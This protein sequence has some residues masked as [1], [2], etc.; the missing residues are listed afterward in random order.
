MKKVVKQARESD[1]RVCG[2]EQARQWDTASVCV[3]RVEG[4][5]SDQGQSRGQPGW[6]GTG[7]GVEGREGRPY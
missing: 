1:T 7:A 2:E 4:C 3:G 5:P 6:G